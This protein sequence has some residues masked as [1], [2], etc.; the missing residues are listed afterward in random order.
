VRR[1]ADSICPNELLER[2]PVGKR[3]AEVNKLYRRRE[4]VK[5]RMEEDGRIAGKIE[6]SDDMGIERR[7]WHL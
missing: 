3:M 2:M 7:Q 4:Y 6:K 5:Q 1:I